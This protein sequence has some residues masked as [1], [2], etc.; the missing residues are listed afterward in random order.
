MQDRRPQLLLLHCI[1]GDVSLHTRIGI[2]LCV[3]N[4]HNPHIQIKSTFALFIVLMH[5]SPIS[6]LFVAVLTI[7]SV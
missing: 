4:R 6:L 2:A 7:Y 3:L 5:N 1:V